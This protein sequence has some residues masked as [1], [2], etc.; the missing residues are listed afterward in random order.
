MPTTRKKVIKT[1]YKDENSDDEGGDF[2]DSGSE[3][4]I[5]EPPSSDE[6]EIE[7]GHSSGDEFDQKSKNKSISRKCPPKKTKF[8][9]SFVA[10]IN[11]Q[12]SNEESNETAPALFSIKDLT[13][14]DKLLPPILNLSESGEFIHDD[15]GWYCT[16][17]YNQ[18]MINMFIR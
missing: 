14:A 17:F 3:A 12:S 4:N 2:S 13:E 18:I 9:K 1:V 5:S 10:K 6:E 8:S 11:K 16:I 15:D 7:S